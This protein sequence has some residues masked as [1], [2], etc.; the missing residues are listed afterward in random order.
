[1]G[2]T[3]DEVTY[4][5]QEIG[6]MARSK[7][8]AF[9]L[10]LFVLIILIFQDSYGQYQITLADY[11]VTGTASTFFADTTQSIPVSVGSAGENQI[12]QFTQEF[13]GRTF[14]A[15]YA[16]PGAS[17]Y[18]TDDLQAAQ[19]VH[20]SKQ[21][22]SSD[23]L[24]G[25]PVLPGFYSF[26]NFERVHN[27]TIFGIGV[28]FAYPPFVDNGYVFEEEQINYPLPLEYGKKWT[29]QSSIT[30][31]I[32]IGGFPVTAV[33]TDSSDISVDGTGQLTIPYGTFSCLRLKVRREITYTAYLLGQ[34]VFTGTDS[35][36]I[37]E[38]H[39]KNGGMLLQLISR[40]GE[41]DENF[42]EASL[43]VRLEDSNVLTGSGC[44]PECP[45]TE[46]TPS[47]FALTQNY[48]NPFSA[49]S[50][51]YRTT[52]EYSLTRTEDL[53]IDVYNQLGR[54]VRSLYSGRRNPG[55]YRIAWD[56]TNEVGAHVPA[57]VYY[58][59]IASGSFTK[60]IKM[61]LVQ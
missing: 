54:K 27:D 22:F 35:L 51:I 37:Y 19:W 11:P 26:D 1:M 16:A 30:D 28:G 34:P 14:T 24:A 4:H 32:L 31:Q 23:T 52:I 61:I 18:Y 3:V 43:V 40:S 50:G 12:W 39:T 48:P 55:N 2:Y 10:A 49:R 25:Q 6:S 13:T 33:L 53:T 9:L 45:A 42:D 5:I 44:E 36:I 56:G 38:W 17:D 58:C 21:W 60:T 46:I 15:E 41:T 57:G 20:I 59:R 7:Q 29:R 8:T 47:K